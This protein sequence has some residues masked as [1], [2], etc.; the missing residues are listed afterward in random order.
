MPGD[1]AVAL[2]SGST[3]GILGGGQ[4]GRMLALAGARLGFKCHI[5]SPDPESPAF[6]VTPLKTV[7]SY[8]DFHAL[9]AF[10]RAVDVITYEFENIDVVAVE[11]LAQLVPVRPG[12]RALAVS[13]DR[14]SEKIFLQGLGLGT[15]PFAPVEHA[16]SLQEALGEIG[17]PAILKARRFGYDGKAQV[18]LGAGDRPDEALKALRGAPAIL[19]GRIEFRCEVSI[20]AARSVDGRVAAYDIAENEHRGGIL[21]RS[22]VPAHCDAD[23][24]REARAAAE[25]ILTALDYVGVIGIEFFVV[26]DDQGERLLVNEFA[27]RVHNSGHWTEDAC[28]TS[29]FENHIRAIAGWPL[30]APTRIADVEML[31]LIGE[32]VDDWQ[33]LA[34]DPRARL[35]LYGKRETRPGRKMGHV[36]RLSPRG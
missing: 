35:H 23:L 19:E 2:P 8:D 34:G 11:R 24:T 3:I 21:V 30:G 7:A 17:L 10:G 31:N 12:A 29:Q 1:P 15:A 16:A 4:L 26:E 14:L 33:R 9:G 27:P 22:T 36:N 5:F 32:E 28:L 6:D 18:M 25:A 13:Q 20:I